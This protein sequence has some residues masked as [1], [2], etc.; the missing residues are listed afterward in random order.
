MTLG[1]SS[2]QLSALEMASTSLCKS[3]IVKN[4]NLDPSF[5]ASKQGYQQN[6]RQPHL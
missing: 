1:A 3:G 4:R 5:L 2:A 6:H